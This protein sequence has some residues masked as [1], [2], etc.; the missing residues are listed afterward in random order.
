V[1][2]TTLASIGRDLGLNLQI[3]L[4]SDEDRAGGRERAS[5]ISDSFEAVIGSVYMDGGLEAARDVVLRL[6]YTQ[7]DRILADSSQRNYKG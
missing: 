1:N 7:R 6:I 4:S 2:E 3:R 5:I